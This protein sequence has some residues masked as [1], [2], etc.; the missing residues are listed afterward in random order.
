VDAY[1]ASVGAAGRVLVIED[2]RLAREAL[3]EALRAAGLEVA[4]AEDGLA[5]LDL[6]EAGWVPAVV[7]LDLYMPRLDGE[8]FLKTLR[9]DERWAHLPVITVTA[10]ESGAP[11]DVLAHVHKP[12]DVAELVEIVLSLCEGAPAPP[13]PAAAER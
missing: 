1:A 8:S 9:A 7:L 5:G 11:P 10:T 13:V 3:S 12:F 2:D 6:L 4:T